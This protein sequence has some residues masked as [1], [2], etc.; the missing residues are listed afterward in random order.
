VLGLVY[1]IWLVFKP[2]A[3]T[4]WQQLADILTG[5]AGGVIHR[6]A[7]TH[8]A[9]AAEIPYALAIAAGAVAAMTYMGLMAEVIIT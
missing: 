6:R 4:L 9:R 5:T 8:S 7:S 3:L 1:L 2:F